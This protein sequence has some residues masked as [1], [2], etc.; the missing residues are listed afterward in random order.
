MFWEDAAEQRFD[1]MPVPPMMKSY[2]RLQA[3]KI[4]RGKGL[5]RVTVET[6]RETEQVYR[7]FVGEEKT[8]Q[9]RAYYAGEGPEPTVMDELFF[10]DEQAL[11][12][13]DVCYTKYGENSDLVRNE[14]VSMMRLLQ[15]LMKEEDLTEIMADRATVAL[16]GASRFTVGMTGCPNCCVSPY[17]KD[18][19]II[20][21]HRVEITDAECTRCGNCLKMCMDR[22]IRLTDTGPVI[23]RSRCTHCELCARDCPTGTLTVEKRGYRVIAGGAGGR[24]PHLAVT[25]VEFVG[26]ER[27]LALLKNAITRLRHAPP[28]ESLR[29][30]ISRD[31]I[32]VL[33]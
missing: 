12:H 4:A 29:D 20:M 17:L 33:R 23:D 19:G 16:H 30:I 7:D 28:G 3:E 8:E 13:I 2:A 11:Y 24:H 10:D 26:R 21:Q 31:G 25:V 18:F 27:V 1:L 6:V 9:L 5:D 15:A 22:A 14:L 32:A